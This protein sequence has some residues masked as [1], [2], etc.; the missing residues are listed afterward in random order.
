[1]N[2]GINMGKFIVIEGCE[3]AGKSTAVATVHKFLVQNGVPD[4]CIVHTRE[5]GGTPIA[6]KI[7]TILK[8]INNEDKMCSDTE[9][10]LMYA[11]RAQLVNTVIKPALAKNY[12]VIGDRHDLSSV[13]YQGAGRG[14]NRTLI[15]SIRKLILGDFVPDLTLVMDLPPEIGLARAGKRG[16]L[17]RFEQ[18]NISFFNRIRNCFLDEAKIHSDR[19]KVINAAN[20]LDKVNEDIVAELRKSLCIVG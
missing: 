18:E 8:E 9:L 15:D 4:N 11:A 13:A 10:L 3:G 1:M 16:E 19:I 7:R 20:N 14:I 6:E 2:K 17:D 12:Y 5:P